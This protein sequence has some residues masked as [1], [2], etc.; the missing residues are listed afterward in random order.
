MQIKTDHIEILTQKQVAEILQIAPATLAKWRCC[1][2]G[3]SF[4]K[5]GAL[6][7]YSRAS[8]NEWLRSVEG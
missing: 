5:I 3:P 4:L 1:G 2:G 8:V 7:R 6:V